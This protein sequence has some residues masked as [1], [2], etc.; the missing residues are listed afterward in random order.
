MKKALVTLAIG[1]KY[2]GVWNGICRKGWQAYAERHGYDVLMFDQPLD[3][4]P[5]A[6]KR[7][8][9]WQKCLILGPS[10]AGGYDRVVWVDSDILIN[11]LAPSIVDTVPV[12][13]IGAVDETVIPTAEERATIVRLC[14]DN[15][16]KSGDAKLTRYWEAT[17]DGRDWHAWYGLPRQFSPIVQTGVMVLSPRHHRELLKHVYN[18]YEDSGDPYMNYEMRPLSHEVQSHQLQHWIDPRFNWM[19]YLF[20]LR[21]RMKTGQDPSDQRMFC[22]LLEQYLRNHFLHFGAVHHLMPMLDLL[23]Q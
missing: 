20:V 17:L 7:S 3:D 11:P 6:R 19:V 4:G 21:A 9:A 23:G 5:R 13:K 16:R 2:R 1:E 22:F 10:V 18:T 15:Y 8:P 12:E 14:I